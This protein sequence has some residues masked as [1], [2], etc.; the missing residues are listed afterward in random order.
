MP[1]IFEVCTFDG[2]KTLRSSPIDSFE[3]AAKRGTDE[4]QDGAYVWIEAM[5]EDQNATKPFAKWGYQ[6]DK[7]INAWVE[8]NLPNAH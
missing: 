6:Y 2:E 3:R 7:H 1:T 8:M 5:P 4:N